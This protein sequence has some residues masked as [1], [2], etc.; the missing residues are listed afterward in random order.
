MYVVPGSSVAVKPAEKEV[1]VPV[2]NAEVVLVLG[3]AMKLVMLVEAPF[4]VPVETSVGALVEAS[5]K[6]D[7]V[8]VPG[9]NEG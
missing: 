8:S 6:L 5:D 1:I 4:K 3:L 7:L 2:I 9:R